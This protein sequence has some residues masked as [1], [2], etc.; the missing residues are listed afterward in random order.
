MLFTYVLSTA[1]F[2]FVG[3]TAAAD[4]PVFT[5]TRVYNTLTDVAPFIIQKTTTF[6]FTASPSTTVAQP[7]GPGA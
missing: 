2:L 1:A 3:V 6:T 7:T 5:A 4:H